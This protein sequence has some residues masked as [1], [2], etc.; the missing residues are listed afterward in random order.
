MNSL[1]PKVR[2]QRVEATFLFS[3]VWSCGA[4]V[5]NDGRNRFDEFVRELSKETNDVKLQCKFPDNLSVY[6]YVWDEDGAKWKTWSS[7]LGRT[8][9]IDPSAVVH[10]IMVP[11]ADSARYRYLLNLLVVARQEVCRH[12]QQSSSLS[13]RAVYQRPSPLS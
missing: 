4:A 3:L 8:Y 13:P 9:H 10:E 6:D 2:Q 11:T 5:D 1:G 7:T 12:H